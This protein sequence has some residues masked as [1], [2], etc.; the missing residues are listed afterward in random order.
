MQLEI[1]YPD[2]LPLVP[3]AILRQHKVHEPFDTRFRSAARLLQ[4]LWRE[5]QGIPMGFYVN[6]KGRKKPLGSRL[7]ALASAGGANFLSAGIQRLAR[8]E[9][10]YRE[11]GAMIDEHRV[12][13]NMLSSMPLTFNLIGGLKL[14]PDLAHQ[15]ART[16]W[17]ELVDE[18]CHIQFEHSP[19][20]GDLAFTADGTAFDA[21]LS[22]RD[23]EGAKTFVAIEVKYSEGMVEPEAKGRP[24]YDELSASCG[25]YR[26]PNDPK[27]RGNPV[28]QLW[29]EHMLAQCLIS[30]RMYDRGVF[31]CL[32]PKLNDPVQR[33]CA[34][35]NGH[36]AAGDNLCAFDT[37]TLEDMLGQ[38]R[39]AGAPEFADALHERYCDFGPVHELI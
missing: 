29:R 4:S 30:N 12:W 2:R 37:L 11:P 19:G 9:M 35:Y 8:R 1:A 15:V 20:R 39:T 6:G 7:S 24:R 17:P 27:L 5:R 31:V 23:A 26:D 25:L 16:L 21:F 36:L 28:Q 34:Q 18:I 3:E 13:S 22:C 33:A 32:A 10:A 14:N 38:I